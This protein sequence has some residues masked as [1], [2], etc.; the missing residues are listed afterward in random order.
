LLG[1]YRPALEAAIEAQ[2]AASVELLQSLFAMLD[3]TLVG[4]KFRGFAALDG[5]SDHARRFVVLEDWL[6]DG[7]PLAGPVARE[8]LFDWYVDNQPGRGTWEVAG[9][10]MRPAGVACPTLALIPSQ[11]RIVPPQSALALAEAIPSATVRKVPLGHIGMVAAG[12]APAL[13][14]EPLINWLKSP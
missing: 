5:A 14:Y 9:V 10:T 7:V 3:P 12:Q 1:L 4:K 13:V 11:D 2:G 8:C 6:N